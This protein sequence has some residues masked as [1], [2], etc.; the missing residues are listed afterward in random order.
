MGALKII[1]KGL[2]GT[3]LNI[4]ILHQVHNKCSEFNK[5]VKIYSYCSLNILNMENSK[6]YHSHQNQATAI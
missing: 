5:Q 4:V 6:K 2:F 3:S 1:G